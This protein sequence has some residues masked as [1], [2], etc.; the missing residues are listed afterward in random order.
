MPLGP[1]PDI[2]RP[3]VAINAGEVNADA[4][5]GRVAPG[6]GQQA[7]ERLAAIILGDV[8]AQDA[9][10]DDPSAKLAAPADELPLDA[11]GPAV[12]A[13]REHERAGGHLAFGVIGIRSAVP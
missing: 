9:I 8:A 4:P 10:V 11:V 13:E 1:R 12:N 3:G 5:A 2:F 6:L 7:I